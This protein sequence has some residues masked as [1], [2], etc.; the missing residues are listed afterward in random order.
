[1]KLYLSYEEH[2]CGGDICKGQENDD[3][4][5]REPTLTTWRLTGCSLNR[6]RTQWYQEEVDI[7]EELEIGDFVYVVYVRYYTGDTFGTHSGCWE[8]LKVLTDPKEAKK[9]QESVE[10]DTYEGERGYITWKGYFEGLESCGIE[11]MTVL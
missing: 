3:W 6:S 2:S 1:M 9:L 11:F 4:P 8:I 10:N 5:D 7:D